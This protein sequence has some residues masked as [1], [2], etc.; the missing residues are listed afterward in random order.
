MAPL[1]QKCNQGLSSVNKRLGK[2]TSFSDRECVQWKKFFLFPTPHTHY[3]MPLSGGR[4]GRE[5]QR[6]KY[7]QTGTAEYTE[8]QTSCLCKFN[9]CLWIKKI[10]FNSK[11]NNAHQ[12]F[13]HHY[14]SIN[15][16]FIFNLLMFS[17]QKEK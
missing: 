6:R 14:E 8:V 7:Y 2:E 1:N 16:I 9:Y 12:L 13:C 3:A 4:E 15:M 11:L 17:V 10:I 5:E